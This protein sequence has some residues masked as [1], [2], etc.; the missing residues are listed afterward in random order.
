MVNLLNVQGREE[1]NISIKKLKGD[2]KLSNFTVKPTDNIQSFIDCR[3]F[4]LFGKKSDDLFL[5]YTGKQ[6]DL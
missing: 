1:L 3:L 5:V 4:E 6:L 2:P